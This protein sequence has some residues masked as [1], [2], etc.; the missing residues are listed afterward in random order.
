[1][2]LSMI[3]FTSLHLSSHLLLPSVV[4]AFQISLLIFNNIA[5]KVIVTDKKVCYFLT[6]ILPTVFHFIVIVPRYIKL[7]LVATGYL[8][9]K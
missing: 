8:K 3:P 1:M 9:R 5:W 4:Y 7:Y 6:L 2:H